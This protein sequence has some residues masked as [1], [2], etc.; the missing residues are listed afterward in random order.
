MVENW[1]VEETRVW[2]A[3]WIRANDNHKSYEERCTFE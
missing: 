1:A 3:L 2:S